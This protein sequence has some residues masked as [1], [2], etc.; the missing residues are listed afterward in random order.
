MSP[1]D[2][3]RRPKIYNVWN[4]MRQRCHN[5]NVVHYARYGAKGIT[6]C[7]RWRNSFQAFYEDIGA[8][9]D[10]GQRWTLDRIDPMKGYSPENVRWATYQQQADNKN[11]ALNALEAF[12]RA[13]KTKKEAADYLAKMMQ[14]PSYLALPDI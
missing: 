11:H 5:P 6:V 9:P 4:A 1:K 14:T 3:S 12:M 7:E 2:V 13:V 10:D 8:P